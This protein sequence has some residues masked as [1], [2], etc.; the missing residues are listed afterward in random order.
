VGTQVRVISRFYLV[1][2]R[3]R[4]FCRRR[5]PVRQ[6]AGLGR[7]G[8]GIRLRRSKGRWQDDCLGRVGRVRVRRRRFMG[9]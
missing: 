6:Q 5:S 7:A 2:P 8:H 3:R 1:W 4:G 9:R